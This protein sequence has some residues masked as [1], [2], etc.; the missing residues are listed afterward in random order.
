[1][2]NFRPCLARRGPKISKRLT[3]LNYPLGS[4]GLSRGLS[5]KFVKLECPFGDFLV[6]PEQVT[7]IQLTAPNVSK[8]G[9]VGGGEINTVRGKPEQIAAILSGEA[10]ASTTPTAIMQ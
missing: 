4:F 6:V 3:S 2:A 7:F 5:M 1:M 8:V 10:P 9:F